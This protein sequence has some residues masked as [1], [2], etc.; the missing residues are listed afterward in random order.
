[1][2]IRLLGANGLK[3]TE[4]IKTERPERRVIFVTGHDSQDYRDE[5]SRIGADGFPSKNRAS[6]EEI[7]STIKSALHKN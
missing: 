2:D 7:V 6:P 5:A 4:R 1:M 3:I